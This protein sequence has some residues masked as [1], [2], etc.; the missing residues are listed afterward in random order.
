MHES[1]HDGSMGR[2]VY[3]PTNLPYKINYSIHVNIQS[4]HK[5]HKLGRHRE[6]SQTQ[7]TKTLTIPHCHGPTISSDQGRFRCFYSSFLG[8]KPGYRI[9]IYSLENQRRFWNLKITQINKEKTSSKRTHFLGSILML[10]G[11]MQTFRVCL[12]VQTY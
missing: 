2:L 1:T 11:V 3:L 9:S 10:Q 4:S 8:P 12:P 6:V 7:T 5:S